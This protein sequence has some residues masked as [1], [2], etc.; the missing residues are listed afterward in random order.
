[1]AFKGATVVL[2]ALWLSPALAA[3]CDAADTCSS[4][5]D[6]MS[7]LQA[8]TSQPGWNNYWER[9]NSDELTQLPW[10][11]KSKNNPPCLQG[12]VFMDQTCQANPELEK[13]YQVPKPCMGNFNYQNEFTTTFGRADSNGCVPFERNTWTFGSKD[14]AQKICA[15]PAP[16]FCLTRESKQ[17]G[18]GPCDVGATYVTQGTSG[19]EFIVTEYG[20]DRKTNFVHYPLLHIVDGRG[21]NT[22]WYD[23]Y[24]KTVTRTKCPPGSWWGCPMSEWA[25][26]GQ[27][28]RCTRNSLNPWR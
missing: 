28:A 6:E 21:R 4:E 20:F 1:M 11:E 18:L 23:L 7:A 25:S 3:E 24:I 14:R 12:I 15:G 10:N 8:K 26:S 9:I 5:G 13:K 17:K 27:V 2:L 19:Y 16:T 22:K